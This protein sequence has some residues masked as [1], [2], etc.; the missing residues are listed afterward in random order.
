MVST[1]VPLSLYVHW[2]YCSFLCR[3]C[4]FSKARVPSGGV[5]HRS[6]TNALLT[7]L[8]TSL[9][10]HTDK[11]LQSIYFGGGTPSLAQP[12]HIAQII[13][14]ANKLVPL[15]SDAEITLESNPTSA[16]VDKMAAFKAAGITRYS[17]GIQTLDDDVLRR[18]GRLH[19]GAEGLAAVN[20][21]RKLFP[22]RV[23]C[24]M[25]FGFDGQTVPAWRRE[26]ETVLEHA[27]NHL[28][29]YQ[30]TVEPGTPLFR[31][32]HS[33]RVVLPADDAQ[34]Q[35]YEAAVELCGSRG[36]QHYEVSNYA[37]SSLS[38]SVHNRG[39]W[40]GRQWVGIGPSA[41]SRFTDPVSGQ[42][43]RTV[44]VPDI[45]RWAQ[46]CMDHG[47]G[48]GKVETVDDAEAKQEAVVF[49]L[50]MLKGLS[51]KQFMQGIGVSADRQQSLAEYLRMDR[52]HQYVR[53]GYLHSTGD[54]AHL[55]PT[56]RGLQ[57]IDSI[58]LDITP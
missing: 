31:D 47:H 48:T 38:Q 49:G 35:M 52:V 53:D 20:R 41:H 56:E 21:A 13:A 23:S 57:V 2:P 26:L 12:E 27:D 11:V 34:A 22:G 9:A 46:S 14:H 44:R 6:I 32:L 19:T 8:K 58:L 50:R 55:A 54:L 39:Y 17:I 1:R 3:F 36:F 16:E 28:S 4:A 18:M 42:R 15:A 10:S 51:N 25:M 40:Q 37:R 29:L 43:L 5:D 7:E 33:Q 45:Q 30:L 24:D